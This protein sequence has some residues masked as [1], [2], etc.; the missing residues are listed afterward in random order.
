MGN[1]FRLRLAKVAI[2]KLVRGMW[3]RDVVHL[4]LSTGLPVD[5]MR[6]ADELKESLLG[7]HVITTDS[8]EIIANITEVRVMPQPY[9]SICAPSNGVSDCV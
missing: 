3:G 1:A 7:Q 8:C 4:R 5:H 2:G 6:D 9:G